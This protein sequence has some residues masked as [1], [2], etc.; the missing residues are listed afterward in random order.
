VDPVLVFSG[1]VS[2]DISVVFS[3]SVASGLGVARLDPLVVG[4]TVV[5]L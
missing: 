4:G 2:G 3:M 5:V 1:L